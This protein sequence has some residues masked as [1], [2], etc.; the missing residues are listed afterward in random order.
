MGPNQWQRGHMS[1]ETLQIAL[2]LV[3]V[4]IVFFGFVR[5]ILPPDIMALIS[6]GV[7]LATGILSTDQVLSVF[8]N[9][10]PITV[11]AMFVLSAALERTGV[12]DSVGR[13]MS[14][15]AHWS[16]TVAIGSMMSAAMGL[17]AFI[18]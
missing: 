4:A 13:L 10:A 14:R 12:I 9:S 1:F 17:S 2:V 6:V 5:E 3:L 7:L 11:S 16:P 8:S 18:N 15:A